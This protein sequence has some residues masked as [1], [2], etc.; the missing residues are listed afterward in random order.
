[1]GLSVTEMQDLVGK[2]AVSA[3]SILVNQA[4]KVR[5]LN[6]ELQDVGGTM[7]RMADDQLNNL[8]GDMKN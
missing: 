5:Q 4:P 2:R 6:D 3:F 1:M 7:Q 8:A